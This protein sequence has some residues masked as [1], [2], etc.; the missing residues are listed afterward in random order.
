MSGQVRAESCCAN[1]TC[2]LVSAFT[3]LKQAIYNLFS[4]KPFASHILLL[5]FNLVIFS[6]LSDCCCN[7]LVHIHKYTSEKLLF[8]ELRLL[9]P[10]VPDCIRSQKQSRVGLGK[11]L[12]GRLFEIMRKPG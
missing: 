12:E 7:F 9:L 5:S 6:S 3:S 2:I 4:Y 8:A 1:F 10:C 11:Y